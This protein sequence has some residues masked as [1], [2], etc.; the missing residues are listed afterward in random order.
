MFI[1]DAIM[2]GADE[3]KILHGKGTGILKT[4]IRKYLKANPAIGSAE[5]EDI[6]YGGSGI[7]VVKMN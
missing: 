3:V 5:D 2:V 6:R 4:E 1:D 7:T